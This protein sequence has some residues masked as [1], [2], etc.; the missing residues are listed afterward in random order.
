M[1][2]HE[3]KEVLQERYKL[4]NQLKLYL[5]QLT[6]ISYGVSLDALKN[7]NYID[8]PRYA[9]AVQKLDIDD[10]LRRMFERIQTISILEKTYLLHQIDDEIIAR[11]NDL[12]NDVRMI[13]AKDG[14]QSTEN[15]VYD[16]QNTHTCQQTQ[17]SFY[18]VPDEEL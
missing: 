10:E 8:D 12:L 13:T 18:E 14:S 1:K 6:R 16:N 2:G 7:P 15:T 5:D 17:D 4:L 11:M 9:A 3:Q